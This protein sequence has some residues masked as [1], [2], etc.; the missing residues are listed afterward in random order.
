MFTVS[1]FCFWPHPRLPRPLPNSS[2]FRTLLLKPAVKF[3]MLPG[4]LSGSKPAAA[5][6]QSAPLEQ[7]AVVGTQ[8]SNSTV[9]PT[10][11][12]HPIQTEPSSSRLATLN[13]PSVWE[14]P[15]RGMTISSPSFA[16]L[17]AP[18]AMIKQA[19][20]LASF[21]IAS[22]VILQTRSSAHFQSGT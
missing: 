18:F 2:V 15:G 13:S 16:P 10:A 3:L 22:T 19:G 11:T 14:N 20:R 9:P 5:E 4:F 12:S 8:E 7:V 21:L 17:R 6:P 1:W